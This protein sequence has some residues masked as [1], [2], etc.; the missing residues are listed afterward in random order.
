VAF[1]VPIQEGADFQGR[2]TA[3]LEIGIANGRDDTKPAAHPQKSSNSMFWNS[4]N[5]NT[6]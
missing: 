2:I 1:Y 3:V 5:T 6:W 4:Y